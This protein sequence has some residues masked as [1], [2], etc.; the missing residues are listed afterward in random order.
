MNYWFSHPN[1]HDYFNN[2]HVAGFLRKNGTG[3]DNVGRHFLAYLVSRY[4]NP[5]VLDVAAGSCVNYEVFKNTGVQCQYTGYDLT[6]KLLDHAKSLYG[7]EI[8]LVKGHAQS[9]PFK[10]KSFDC[11]LIRHLMEHLVPPSEELVLSEALRVASKEVILVFFLM[12]NNGQEHINEKRPSNIEGHPE[13]FHYWRTYS[14]PKLANLFQ[15]WNLEYQVLGPIYT[16][17]AAAPD[18]IIRL[19]KK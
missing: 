14:W 15:L 6:Q 12:P 13:V 18:L 8:D 3:T 4:E 1:D 5:K 17:G 10:D 9:L 11:V 16:Q 2:E 7:N 19:N